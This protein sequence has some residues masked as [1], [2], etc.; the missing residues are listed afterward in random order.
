VNR[1][2]R[3]AQKARKRRDAIRA[4]QHR[5]RSE[6]APV[7][8]DLAGGSEPDEGFALEDDDTLPPS[9]AMGERMIAKIHRLVSQ[10]NFESADEANEF[11]STLMGQS[12]DDLEEDS[13]DPI[14]RAQDLAFDAMDAD[15]AQE[16]RRLAEGALELDPECVDAL[17]LV[18][19]FAPSP[20]AQAAQLRKAVKAAERRLGKEF[21]EENKGHFWGLPETRPY[22]RARQRL[23]RVLVMQ[24][25]PHEATGHYEALLELCPNDNLGVRFDLVGH[26]LLSD[27]MEAALEV[28]ERYREDCTAFMKWA[29]VLVYFALRRFEEA[30]RALRAARRAN[31]HV[32]RYF[33]DERAPMPDMPAFYGI[34]DKNEAA[35]C[36]FHQVIAWRLRPLAQYWLRSGGRPGDGK[37]LGCFQSFRPPKHY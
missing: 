31:R 8:D 5:Q 22:M 6:P 14:E 21:F 33:V 20:N 3:H 19:L 29:A 37:Y 28:V 12:L 30:E 9:L 2:K 7:F 18:S 4:Q 1:Q 10:K 25:R 34:G 15:D 35:Y 17:V 27:E 11:L 32:E 24:K 13:G 26:Y 23:A 36:A 16:A